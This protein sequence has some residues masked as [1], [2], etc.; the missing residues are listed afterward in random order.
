MIGQ[1]GVIF[2]MFLI[3]VHLDPA[4]FRGQARLA[5][6][7]SKVSIAV[8]FALG[9]LLSFVLY[10]PF[11][12]AGGSLGVFAL[13]VGLSMSVTAFPV[14][15]RILDDRGLTKTNLGSIALTCAAVNDVVAWFLLALVVG[16]AKASFGGALQTLVLFVV[17][18]LFMFVVL[19]P[20]V[21]KLAH[22]VDVRGEVGHGMLAL[23]VVALL[24]SALATE[25]IG[26]HAL[27]GA[28]LFGVILPP[29]G[30]L[31]QYLN[32]CLHE[33]VLVFLLPAYFAFTGLRTQIGLI[34]GLD[35]WLVC[36]LII[37]VA[38]LGKAG[39][40]IFGARLVGMDWLHASAL[41]ALMNTRGLM[42]II[43]LNIGLDLHVLS[44][45]LFAML[46]LMA[47]VTTMATTPVLDR[48]T[49]RR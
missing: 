15:A 5:V 1:L 16:I 18:V 41:G 42:E 47:I 28:F 30:M 29:K 36:G 11:A 6:V 24:L 8:P 20:L 32:H 22:H 21:G 9:A 31:A 19:R 39:G 35:Q 44:P 12:P 27:F 40:T 26:I 7:T 13:F 14:L 2:Y 4:I 10:Q 23:I 45:T 49:P 37:V 43:V 38:T 3:G 17:F 34:V 25:W 46:V 48:L 33:I